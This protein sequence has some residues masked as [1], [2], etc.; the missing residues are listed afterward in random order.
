[1]HLWFQAAAIW[2]K[3]IKSNEIEVAMLERTEVK[4]EQLRGGEPELSLLICRRGL[5]THFFLLLSFSFMD[6][7]ASPSSGKLTELVDLPG[8]PKINFSVQLLGLFMH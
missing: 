5:G 8:S 2:E 1:M 6:V 3:I 7:I 4:L